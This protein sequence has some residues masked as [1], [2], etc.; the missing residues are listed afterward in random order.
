[1][2][3]NYE[4]YNITLTNPAA[5]YYCLDHLGCQ[6]IPAD[7]TSRHYVSRPLAPNWFSFP[8]SNAYVGCV[9]VT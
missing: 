3:G 6:Y 5:S 4:P 2:V 9:M 8:N 1:M 7:E